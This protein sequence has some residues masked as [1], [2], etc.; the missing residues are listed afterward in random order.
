MTDDQRLPADPNRDDRRADRRT[1]AGV[2]TF[3]IGAAIVSIWSARTEALRDGGG[4]PVINVAIYE[5]TSAV[6]IIALLPLV[7]RIVA[8]ATP[9]RAPL[10]RVLLTHAAGSI[11]FSGLHILGMVLLRKLIFAAALGGEYQFFGPILQ[12]LF[13]EYRKDVLTYTLLVVLIAYGREL[14]QAGQEL[15]A[16]RAAARRSARVTLK[17]GGDTFS[18]DAAA[19]VWARAA[20]NYVEVK[21]GDREFLAR[22]TLSGLCDAIHAAGGHALRVHRSHVVNPRRLVATALAGDGPGVATLDDGAIVPV[23]RRYRWVLET[24]QATQ[25]DPAAP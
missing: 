17:S 6:M 25:P 5:L 7:A 12:E 9:G 23:S 2:A 8:L 16:A 22:M 13:Y 15:A 11:V 19:F 18:F 1:F 14:V 4:E 20:G 21:A 10:L 3:V 24:S